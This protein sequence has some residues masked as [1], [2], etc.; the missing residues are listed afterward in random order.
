MPLPFPPQLPLL[1]LLLLL[2]AAPLA[3]A[4]P[5]PP[6][7]PAP[8][9]VCVGGETQNVRWRDDGTAPTASVGMPLAAGETLNYDGDLNR[10]R[11]I[12][13]S[14]GAVLNVSYYA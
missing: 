12:Q 3:L 8:L 11:F 5:P 6:S 13:Q 4:Q 9:T 2:L 10:I 1:L 7:L 14:S